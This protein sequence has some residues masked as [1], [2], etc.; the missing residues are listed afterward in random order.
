MENNDVSKKGV[1]RELFKSKVQEIMD[2]TIGPHLN[3]DIQNF[4]KL[5]L[6]KQY[7][8]SIAS[9]S[10]P[11]SQYQQALLDLKKS[12]TMPREEGPECRV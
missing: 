2:A 12:C 10:D 4:L 3:S 5:W 6:F 11:H 9:K 8:K 1:K 7:T